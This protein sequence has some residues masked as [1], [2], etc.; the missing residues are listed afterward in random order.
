MNQHV[1]L[2]RDDL[3]PRE[4]SGEFARNGVIVGLALLALVVVGGVAQWRASGSAAELAGLIDEQAAIQASMA[5][6]SA[7]LAERQPDLAVTQALLEA[8][9]AVDSRAW[10]ASQLAASG[11]ETVAFS[12]VLA[13]LGRQR[14]EPLWL[15]GIRIAHGG[16]ALGL[17]GRALHADVVP[18]Y[19][20]DLATEEAL[21]GREFSHFRIARAVDAD[22][23][24]PALLHFEMA[25]DCIA[26]IDGCEPGLRTEGQ[27]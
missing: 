3:R 22:A 23:A 21:A 27:P 20:E 11:N 17:S 26:L 10:L 1:D 4:S 14:P 18:R 5:E 12:S 16:E 9:F 8:Q 24:V 2:Y 7:R 15:T 6:V 25:T 19:L 13:G